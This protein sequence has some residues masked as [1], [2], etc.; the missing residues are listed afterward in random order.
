MNHCE[1]ENEDGCWCMTVKIPQ[2]L[3]T[4]LPKEAQGAQCICLKCAT[5]KNNLNE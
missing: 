2:S 4:N 1:I 5:K 3:I